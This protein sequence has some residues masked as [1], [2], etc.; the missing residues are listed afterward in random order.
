[1][2]DQLYGHVCMCDSLVCVCVCVCVCARA[3]VCAR[4]VTDDIN[5][6]THHRSG[7]ITAKKI[8]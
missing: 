5:M 6:I 2:N 4:I 8:S 1:M 7:D 3:R